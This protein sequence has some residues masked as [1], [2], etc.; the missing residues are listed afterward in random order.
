MTRVGF[1]RSTL[2]VLGPARVPVA[3]VLLA[4]H[5]D[6]AI[7]QPKVMGLAC[8]PGSGPRSTRTAGDIDT[9]WANGP[10]QLGSEKWDRPPAQYGG[11]PRRQ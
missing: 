11:A 2:R 8:R 7:N 10:T 9:G 6:D 5:A 4:R 1:A 3:A